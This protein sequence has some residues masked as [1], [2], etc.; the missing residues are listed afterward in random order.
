MVYMQVTR[1]ADTGRDFAFPKAAIKLIPADSVD[2]P[3]QLARWRHAAKLSHPH[4]IRILEMGRCELD[5]TPMLY[6]VM[7][8]FSGYMCAMKKRAR[9]R[10]VQTRF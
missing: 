2:A 3:A 5:S 1:G 6:V 10:Q 8:L 9:S 7:E 4:L